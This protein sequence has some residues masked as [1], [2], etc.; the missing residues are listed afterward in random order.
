MKRTWDQWDDDMGP[1]QRRPNKK[2][3]NNP[4][5]VALMPL[6]I[7]CGIQTFS[8]MMP[9]LRFSVGVHVDEAESE[10]NAILSY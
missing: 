3:L 6:A 4:E 8:E 7:C 2:N 10:T 9:L 1:F 5:V